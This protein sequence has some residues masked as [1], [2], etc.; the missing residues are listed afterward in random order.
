MYSL[1][2]FEAT[3][4]WKASLKVFCQACYKTGNQMWPTYWEMVKKLV[5]NGSFGQIGRT[6]GFKLNHWPQGIRGQM[7]YSDLVWQTTPK[8]AWKPETYK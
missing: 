1:V 4:F 3:I 5:K 8:N 6:I 7:A 2:I